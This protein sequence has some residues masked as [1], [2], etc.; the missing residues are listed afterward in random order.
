M[1]VFTVFL[2]FRAP[3]WIFQSLLET[4]VMGFFALFPGEK[5]AEVGGQVSA[6]L[7]RHV[8]SWTLAAYV[9]PRGFREE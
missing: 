4:L 1:V 7:P 6:D 9:Q 2:R 5:S 3:Q 8:S